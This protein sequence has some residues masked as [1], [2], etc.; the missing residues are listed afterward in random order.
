MIQGCTNGVIHGS[1]S[2]MLSHSV[3]CQA[4]AGGVVHRCLT[5]FDT[6]LYHHQTCD[7]G[8]WVLPSVSNV[9]GQ[10]TLTHHGHY[11]PRSPCSVICQHSPTMTTISCSYSPI[12]PTSCS[13]WSTCSQPTPSS[14][15]SSTMPPKVASGRAGS[16]QC[17]QRNSAQKRAVEGAQKDLP[18][19]G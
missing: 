16:V 14:L 3:H 4:V 6:R 1:P 11:R 18:A 19:S 7:V 5:L 12:S 13:M 9:Q 15:S 17:L 10:H 2:H 8:F